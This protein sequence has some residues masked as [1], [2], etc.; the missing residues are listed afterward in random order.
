MWN[1]VQ[2]GTDQWTESCR[3]GYT[4][5][6][7]SMKRTTLILSSAAVALIGGTVAAQACW[8]ERARGQSRV[9]GYY[10]QSYQPGYVRTGSYTYIDRD[11]RRVD[12]RRD[13]RY[14]DRDRR[15]TERQTP[16]R[17]TTVRTRARTGQPGG[18]AAGG[19]GGPGT[20]GPGA[21]GTGGAGGGGGGN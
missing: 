17:R 2:Y 8:D 15:Y 20:G 3:S 7:H 19:T 4:L 12:R 6:N 10:Q 5:E 21:G 16:E 1:F 9:Y 11:G 14:S 18:P 13:R